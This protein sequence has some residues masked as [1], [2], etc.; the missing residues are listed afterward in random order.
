M[1]DK[2]FHNQINSKHNGIFNFKYWPL[3][4]ALQLRNLENWYLER[5]L[6]A[7]F[8]V[9]DFIVCWT[10]LVMDYFMIHNKNISVIA[11]K[12]NF[13]NHVFFHY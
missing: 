13:L 10:Y 12:I 3:G 6:V 8:E 7:K 9:D 11:L 5:H 2:I 4:G 1:N